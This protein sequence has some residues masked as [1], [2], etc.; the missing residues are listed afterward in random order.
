MVKDEK[1]QYFEGSQK[2]LIFSGTQIPK[3]PKCSVGVLKK[4]VRGAWTVLKFEGD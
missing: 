2:N 3:K 4:G 1:L